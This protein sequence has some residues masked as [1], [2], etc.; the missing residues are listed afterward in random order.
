MIDVSA[1]VAEWPT[2]G[3]WRV[4]PGKIWCSKNSCIIVGEGVTRGLGGSIGNLVRL[5]DGVQLEAHVVISA[6]AR[7]G[8]GAH[9]GTGARILLGAEV[10][11]D[12]QIPDHLA[13]GQH[14]RFVDTLAEGNS[15][16]A[17]L[18]DVDGVAYIHV[19][20]GW[21]TIEDA[22]AIKAHTSTKCRLRLGLSRQ[23]V[24]RAQALAALNNLKQG[25]NYP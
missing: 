25:A 7:I 5:G 14:A 13:V 3:R 17:T 21:F 18:T 10:A 4:S 11:A 8:A 6:G 24:G 19:V 12:T 23:V 2:E 22:V 1:A 9:I 20:G 16:K 15:L